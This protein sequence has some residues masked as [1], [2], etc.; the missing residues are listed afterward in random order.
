LEHSI[1]V[2]DLTK[3]YGELLAVDHV[4]FKV[5]RGEVFGFLGPNGAGKTTTIKMLVGLTTPSGGTAAVGGYDIRDDIVEVKR[6]VGVVPESSN[7]YDELTVWENLLF[8]SRLYHV[9]RGERPGRIE[10]LLET[11]HLEDRRDTRFGKLSKGLKR[12]VVIAAALV[13]EPEIVFMDEPTAGLDVIS[14]LSLR[15]FIGE[16]RREE[17]TVFLTTHYIEEADQ[18]SDRVA[19]LVRGRIVAV[20]APESIKMSVR[21]VPKIEALLARE[22]EGSV[23]DDLRGLGRVELEGRRVRVEVEDVNEALGRLVGI[24]SER[25]IEIMDVNTLRPSL[26]EAFVGLTGL[27]PEAMM[28]EKERGRG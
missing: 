25:G 1:E 5:R 27:A 17:T 26:E 15:R 12:R 8:A 13:H 24:A 28:V 9:P 20:D 23:V 3:Y 6:R 16:L 11:F 19:I 10:G 14:A 18:L 7:L 4:S 22:P 21:A 2:E